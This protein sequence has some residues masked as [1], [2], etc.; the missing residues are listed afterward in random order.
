MKKL[1]IV[2]AILTL[3]PT[4]SFA[5]YI[6]AEN[7]V[8][9]PQSQ[10]GAGNAYIAGKIVNVVNP[11]NG[12]LLAAGGTVI[13]SSAIQKDIMAAGGTVSVLGAMAEDIRIVGGTVTVGG[14]FSGELLAAGGQINVISGTNIILDSYIAGGTV[15]FAGV[16]NG[17]L[18]IFG[19]DV[20]I[21]GT[22]GGNLVVRAEKINIGPHAVIKGNLEYTAP[23]EMSM[24]SGAT[25]IGQTIFHKTE[26]SRQD[27]AGWAALAAILGILTAVKFL[28]MLAIAYLLWYF[29]RKDIVAII[30]SA[31][32]DF[33]K[34]FLRGFSFM[35]LVPVAAIII[36]MTIIGAVPAILGMLVYGAILII[37]GAVAV[38]VAASLLETFLKKNKTEFPWYHI[39]FAAL[40]LS[41]ISIIPLVGWAARFVIFMLALGGVVNVLKMKF[42]DNG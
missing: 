15:V 29:R 33:W 20:R 36:F 17:S 8:L 3:M 7:T 14:K 39:L 4:V 23:A 31:H 13:V 22:V 10:S 19:R 5:A 25:V 21:D 40:I 27:K 18:T 16:E 38:L 41:F 28:S 12:D 37:S 26:A 9:S 1:T 34:V 35:I 42:R 11:V 2:T 24:E 30:E 6:S 32:A